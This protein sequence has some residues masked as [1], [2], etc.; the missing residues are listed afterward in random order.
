MR[1]GDSEDNESG[2][3]CAAAGAASFTRAKGRDKARQDRRYCRG[4]LICIV[5]VPRT[6]LPQ[7]QQD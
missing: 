3:G 2:E 4:L 1:S 6:K 7:P 5:P